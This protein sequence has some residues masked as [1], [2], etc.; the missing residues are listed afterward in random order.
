VTGK[1]EFKSVFKRLEEKRIEGF[2][3]LLYP[4]PL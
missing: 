3:S 4:L 1:R 2:I